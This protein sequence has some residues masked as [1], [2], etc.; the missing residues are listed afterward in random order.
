[1]WEVAVC[2]KA[3]GDLFHRLECLM[4]ECD[5]CGGHLFPVCPLESGNEE[6]RL[7]WRRFATENIGVDEEGRPKTRV[8]EVH[9]ETSLPEFFQYLQPVLHAFI[10]HN[11]V[12]KWQ[13]V[14]CRKSMVD[15]PRDVILS[16]VDFAENYTF[17]IQNEI[18]SMHWQNTQISIFVHVTYRYDSV[19]G[20]VVRESHFYISDDRSH[21]TLFVQH[22]FILHWRWL[23][24][25]NITVQRHWVWSD[26]CAGTCVLWS[27]KCIYS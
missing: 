22:C 6:Y 20:S 21:D 24:A 10:T 26:G 27:Y 16:H 13:D 12:A 5:R 3:E 4:G 1:M 18:Q 17:Q 25:H 11:F 7:K 14:N 2:A 23:A 19:V 15:M 8:G 9:M